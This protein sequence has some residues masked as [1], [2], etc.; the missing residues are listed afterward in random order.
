MTEQEAKTK[1]CPLNAIFTTMTAQ[2][3]S[4]T[5]SVRES[6]MKSILCSASECMMWRWVEP[7][8]T[9]TDPA[10]EYHQKGYC[11]LGGKP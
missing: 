7:S 10:Q 2:R 8:R 4:I 5:E 9:A 1:W 6:F 3:M 11:G